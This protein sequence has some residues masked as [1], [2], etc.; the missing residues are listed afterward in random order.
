MV[1]IISLEICKKIILFYKPVSRYT[2][3]WKLAVV[4]ICL[5]MVL[6]YWKHISVIKDTYIQNLSQVSCLSEQNIL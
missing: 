2:V 6:N 4:Y 1:H 5:I 3:G